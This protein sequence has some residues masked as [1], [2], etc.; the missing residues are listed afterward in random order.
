MSGF[1]PVTAG[2]WPTT[3]PAVTASTGTFTS[4]SATVAYLQEGKKVSVFGKVTITTIGTASGRAKVPLPVGEKVGSS[5]V[6]AAA[7]GSIPS[8]IFGV[9]YDASG[10]VSL[11]LTGATS[12]T[13]LVFSG[14]YEAA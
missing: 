14:T 2:A 11:D 10:S 4:V 3:T 9:V 5:P 12:G 8:V 1:S 6:F 13:V 7:N